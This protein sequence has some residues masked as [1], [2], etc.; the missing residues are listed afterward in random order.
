MKNEWNLL[1]NDVLKTEK[2]LRRQ[3]VVDVAECK[4]W[5]L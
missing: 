3:K 1:V 4:P 5:I 2:N